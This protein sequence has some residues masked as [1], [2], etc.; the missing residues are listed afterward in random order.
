MTPEQV[1]AA[2]APHLHAAR[3]GAPW[4]RE[5]WESHVGTVAAVLAHAGD[6]DARVHRA[7]AFREAATLL[8]A[9]GWHDA[10]DLLREEAGIPDPDDLALRELD[11][12]GV[13]AAV[14][15]PAPVLQ[16]VREEGA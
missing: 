2:V 3:H 9:G 1:A 8:D 16:L 11:L 7:A 14:Q 6:G 15:E 4:H 12:E 10:A 13:R 5:A